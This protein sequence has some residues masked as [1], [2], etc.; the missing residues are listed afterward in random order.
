MIYRRT[1]DRALN[2]ISCCTRRNWREKID[3]KQERK[4][5]RGKGE[6]WEENS[7][8]NLVQCFVER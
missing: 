1:V 5:D 8:N 4:I 2:Y 3:Y 6:G 7:I